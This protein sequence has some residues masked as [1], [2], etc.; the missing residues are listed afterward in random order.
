MHDGV[1]RL[2]KM[3]TQEP[4]LSS[5]ARFVEYSDIVSGPALQ[6]AVIANPCFVNV[7][8]EFGHKLNM[9]ANTKQPDSAAMSLRRIMTILFSKSGVDGVTGGIKYSDATKSVESVEGVA[10]SLIGETTPA[11]FFELLTPSMMAD[12]FMSRFAVVEYSGERPTENRLSKQY[13]TMSKESLRG[14][15]NLIWHALNPSPHK[16]PAEV[17]CSFDAGG[18]L[19]DFS[20]ECDENIVAAGDNDSVRQMWS[21]AHLKVLKIAAL[22]AVADAG[23]KGS[24]HACVEEEHA[25]WAIDF[26]RRDIDTFRTRLDSG[27]VGTDDDARES[28]LLS[29]AT[30]FLSTKPGELPESFKKFEHLR[31][32][33][34][35]PRKYFQQM[36]SQ[37]PAFRNHRLQS[38]KALNEALESLVKAGHF[39]AVL[40]QHAVEQ[41]GFPG[42]CYRF[43]QS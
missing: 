34:V 1:A 40:K 35:I 23:P 30:K 28:K 39:Q 12:G 43:L 33:A 22:L 26:I 14:L 32:A 38:T 41:Y 16:R 7:T 10:Y 19:E 8:S 42:D 31:A 5:G 27:D 11:T 25:G 9:I 6:K 29:L 24:L 21:R 3:A 36:T 17:P 4:S 37:L 18:M 2:I 15:Q 20:Y 13:K